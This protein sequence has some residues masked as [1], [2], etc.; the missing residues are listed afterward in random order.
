MNAD[1]R[2]SAGFELSSYFLD[3]ILARRRLFVSV[4]DQYGGGQNVPPDR[5]GMDIAD[6]GTCHRRRQPDEQSRP[7]RIA[8]KRRRCDLKRRE[9]VCELHAKEIG[10]A[11]CRERV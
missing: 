10:R 2:K 9:A 5:R 7:A 4:G 11:S 3:T 6:E 1:G 8:T